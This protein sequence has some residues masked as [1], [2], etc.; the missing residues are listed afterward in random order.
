LTTLTPHDDPPLAAP[1]PAPD[2]AVI[3][4]VS[5]ATDPGPAS[6]WSTLAA[7][8]N[9]AVLTIARSVATPHRE[10][11]DPIDDKGFALKMAD[12]DSVH[13]ER[14][15]L[16]ANNLE[17][18]D[19]PKKNEGL[20]DLGTALVW[21][22]KFRNNALQKCFIISQAR[23]RIVSRSM[24]IFARITEWAISMSQRLMFVLTLAYIMTGTTCPDP[25]GSFAIAVPNMKCCA[26]PDT[27]LTYRYDKSTRHYDK[28]NCPS[29]ISDKGLREKS[30]FMMI[31]DSTDDCF[32][33]SHDSQTHTEKRDW[34]FIMQRESKS[35][36]NTQIARAHRLKEGESNNKAMITPFIDVH[37]ALLHEAEE[38][39]ILPVQNVKYTDGFQACRDHSVNKVPF[40]HVLIAWKF[41]P[42]TYEPLGTPGW[43]KLQVD[44]VPTVQ[45]WGAPANSSLTWKHEPPTS[46]PLDKP[47]GG[48]KQGGK[49]QLK[50]D[51][52]FE[53]TV[54]RGAIS[55][56][57]LIGE[58]DWMY[59][60]FLTVTMHVFIK[61]F[62]LR[63]K[64]SSEN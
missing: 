59:S 54:E 47:E 58:Y 24:P 7:A 20:V 16:E 2:P 25:L 42:S 27:Q 45:N 52:A 28:S 12:A 35:K 51:E 44:Q 5:I 43:N 31:T 33:L 36:S 39:I 23:P 10:K 13:L 57:L 48:W 40:Q 17:D 4:D 50:L 26:V 49:Q 64:F 11:D 32:P 60:S 18:H 63:D 53:T 41:D 1:D 15:D 46:Q 56:E 22:N 19:E 37:T 61:V 9:L 6:S 29:F 3:V 14:L 38:M 8:Q 30:T 62:K 34:N 21:N 55:C